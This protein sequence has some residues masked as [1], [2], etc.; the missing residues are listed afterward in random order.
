MLEN[1]YVSKFSNIWPQAFLNQSLTIMVQGK[2]GSDMKAE[3]T[4]HNVD[5]VVTLLKQARGRKKSSGGQCN[6]H[7]MLL[8]DLTAMPV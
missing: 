4:N 3:V 8:N 6:L 5:M 2:A 1:Q 7:K